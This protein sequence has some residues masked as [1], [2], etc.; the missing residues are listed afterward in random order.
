MLSGVK[1]LT[2]QTEA[3]HKKTRNSKANCS[4][5]WKMANSEEIQAVILQGGNSG[6]YSDGKSNEVNTSAEPHTRRTSRTKTSRTNAKSGSIWLEGTRK[7]CWTTVFQNEGSKCAASKSMWSQW[8]REGTHYKELVRQIRAAIYT[9]VILQSYQ[10]QWMYP[11]IQ[12]Y[13]TLSFL[14]C[15]HF[16][17]QCP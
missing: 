10:L 7:V 3:L 15:I 13:V 11:S 17:V 6:S 9:D 8:Q 2:R 4:V 12:K 14:I 1:V 5:R 16:W